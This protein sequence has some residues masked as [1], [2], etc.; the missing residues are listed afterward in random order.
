[1]KKGGF[2]LIEIC[3]A[4]AIFSLAIT[5]LFGFLNQTTKT[6]ERSLIMG[7][8]IDNTSYVLEYM[9][10]A[11]R[12]AKKDDLGGVNC[13]VGNK[14]NYEIT[15]AGQG[16]KFRNYKDECQEFFLESDKLKEWKNTGGIQAENFFTPSNIEIGDFKIGP[17][18]TWD[19]ND[20]Q[21]PRVTLYL[22]AVYSEGYWSNSP[23]LLDVQTTVSQR[24]LDVRR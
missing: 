24:N 23:L 15:R 1:M 18:D 7:R 6:Q 19:Q 22:K 9:S 8:M 16:I 10:R 13:L 17:S 3:V 12:M 11:L 5:A 4:V 2:T 20:D 21:Q 14:V